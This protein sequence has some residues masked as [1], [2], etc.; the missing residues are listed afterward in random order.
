MSSHSPESHDT[1]TDHHNSHGEES[2]PRP[3]PPM[4]FLL[5]SVIGAMIFVYGMFFLLPFIWLGLV[6]VGLGLVFFYF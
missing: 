4:A 5:F 2:R 1:H 3:H 6:V